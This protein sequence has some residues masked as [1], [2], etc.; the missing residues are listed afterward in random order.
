MLSYGNQISMLLEATETA[1]SDC[2]LNDFEV[3]GLT[4]FTAQDASGLMKNSFSSLRL[5]MK[6]VYE[7]LN[8]PGGRLKKRFIV[9]LHESLPLESNETIGAKS[10]IQSAF[11][12]LVIRSFF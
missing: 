1:E 12:R 2:A 4:K 7:N 11:Q 8:H 3:T 9:K 10:A 6:K 5:F